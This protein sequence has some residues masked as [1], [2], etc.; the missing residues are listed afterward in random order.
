MAT[1][2]PGSDDHIVGN[3]GFSFKVESNNIFGFVIV[4]DSLDAAFYRIGMAFG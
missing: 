1:R 2:S 4:E 3:A